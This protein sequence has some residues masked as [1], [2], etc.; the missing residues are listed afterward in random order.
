MLM[1]T[2]TQ[3][4]APLAVDKGKR[5]LAHSLKLFNSVSSVDSIDLKSLGMTQ[6]LCDALVRDSTETHQRFWIMDNSGSMATPDGNRFVQASNKEGQLSPCTRWK[7][8]QET[9]IYHSHL[10]GFLQV[11]TE[12]Q[13]LNSP[14]TIYY[15]Q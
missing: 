10:A 11:P 15:K 6:G 3:A 5:S 12:F 1:S 9:A 7:E 8:L 14:G 2:K 4:F 13:F